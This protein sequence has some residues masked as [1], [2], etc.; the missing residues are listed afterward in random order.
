MTPSAGLGSERPVLSA[1]RRTSSGLRT[2]RLRESAWVVLLANRLELRRELTQQLLRLGCQ[3]EAPDGP[4]RL[5]DW[6][7]N[8]LLVSARP[9]WPDL[10]ILVG[11]RLDKRDLD[12]MGG[13]RRAGWPTAFL[14]AG[15]S[16]RQARQFGR[17]ATGR[18]MVADA[19]IEPEDLLTAACW[20]LEPPGQN[21]PTVT[22]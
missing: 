11:G 10:I 13:L 1:A 4:G 12:V 6:V 2:L 3:V 20:L 17:L 14:L 5:A 21:R 7:A 9:R 22:S 8:L 19:T 16:Q 15:L 18:V